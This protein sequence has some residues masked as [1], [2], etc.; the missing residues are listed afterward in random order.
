M[1]LAGQRLQPD[2]YAIIP[3]TLTFL[4]HEDKILLI[5]LAEDR[6]EWAGK[7]NG[8]GGHIERGEDPSA[9]ARREIREETGLSPKFLTLCGVII[10]DTGGSPGI[11]LYVYV[12]ET[13]DLSE[14]H[15]SD[16]GFPEW[17]DYS[18]IMNLPLVEDLFILIPK[19]TQAYAAKDPFSACYTYDQEGTLTI[20]FET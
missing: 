17:L 16:E 10:V 18:E 3:R 6:G 20:H 14:A 19:S 2:R 1:S 4:V 11:G 8:I 15:P 9:S 7:Y 12:G 5:R 13:D